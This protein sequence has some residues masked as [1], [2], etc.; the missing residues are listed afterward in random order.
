[1]SVAFTREESAE[2][3]AEVE[4]PDRPVSPHAN[5]VTASG[6]E[7]LANAMAEYRAAYNAAHRIEDVIERRR[8]VALA[9]REMRY[10][11]DRLRTAQLIPPPIAFDAVAFGH[12]V[13]FRRDDGRRQAFRIVGEDEAD[14][15]NGS[16]SYVSPVA[17][18]LIGKAADDVVLVGDHEIQILSIE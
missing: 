5:L 2:T 7:A 11:A 18:A 14:P 1:M 12:R 10:F 17:R 8:A 6:L 13:T 4:L 9:S 3:A 16:I 15:R